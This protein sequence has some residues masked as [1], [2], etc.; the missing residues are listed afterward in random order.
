[1]KTLKQLR[2]DPRISKIVLLD[3]NEYEHKYEI[4]LNDCY[5]FDGSQI[6]FCDTVAEINEIMLSAEPLTV[7]GIMAL[8]PRE[9][10][11]YF[12]NGKELQNSPSRNTPVKSYEINYDNNTVY[13]N[14]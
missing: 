9:K 8:F 2:E 12:E 1:M 5:T 7:D 4:V 6:E 10:I 13:V 11:Y 14:V 3:Q